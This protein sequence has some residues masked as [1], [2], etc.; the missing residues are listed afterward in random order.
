MSDIRDEIE[1]KHINQLEDMIGKGASF[2]S[3]KHEGI[4][5]VIIIMYHDR[6]YRLTLTGVLAHFN[7]AGNLFNGVIGTN[8]ELRAEIING[9]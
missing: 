1:L 7:Y 6:K 9:H 8:A 2:L 3:L 4:S 5:W